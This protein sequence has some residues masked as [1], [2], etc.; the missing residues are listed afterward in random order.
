MCQKNHYPHIWGHATILPSLFSGYTVPT[1]LGFPTQSISSRPNQ[2]RA[3]PST[4]SKSAHC[5]PP[6]GRTYIFSN[7]ITTS[8]VLPPSN[9][10]VYS[11][12]VPNLVHLTGQKNPYP[13]MGARKSSPQLVMYSLHCTYVEPKDFQPT[14]SRVGRINL[15]PSQATVF[16]H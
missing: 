14:A 10:F 12:G 15:E 5:V 9:H 16:K 13:H 2:L 8:E 3:F 11:L 1:V 6:Y 7:N 4:A